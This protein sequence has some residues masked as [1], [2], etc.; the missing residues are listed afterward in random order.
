MRRLPESRPPHSVGMNMV[1]PGSWGQ[2]LF[3]DGCN[4][5]GGAWLLVGTQ[6][7]EALVLWPTAPL[8]SEL[9]EGKE[10]DRLARRYALGRHRACH[11]GAGSV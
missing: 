9:S 4:T 5:E 11:L 10:G 7:P 3:S 2:L 8:D 6:A 1:L